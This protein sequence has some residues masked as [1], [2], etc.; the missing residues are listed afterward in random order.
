MGDLRYALHRCSWAFAAALT[1]CAVTCAASAA[2]A[3]ATLTVSTEGASLTGRIWFPKSGRPPFPAVVLVHGSGRMTRDDMQYAR[4][5]ML[6]MGLAVLGYDKRG[7]GESTGEYD[8]V[9]V[10][11][12]PTRMPLLGRDALAMLR[13]LRRHDGVDAS[14]VGF[15]GVSQAGWIIPAALGGAR[16]GE[17]GFA[18]IQSGP[19]GS[20]GD[21][22]A[23][24]QATGDGIRSHDD[25]TPEQIDARVDAYEG[26]AGF[27]NLPILRR[28]RT[29]LLWLVGEAD[30]SIPVRHTLRNLKALADGGVPI[31]LRT[32]PGANHSL[33][34]P[35]GPVPFWDDVRAWLKQQRVLD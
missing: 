20:V 8:D 2:T 31:A 35:S 13:A 25:L 7:V 10:F 11:T 15:F 6:S 16:S 26:P 1:A 21:E 3:D 4:A 27:D 19:A 28:V 5:H 33:S 34:A 22:Y 18:I 9:G 23:Y 29:P 24:S 30:E 12:S 14:R 32:Y 17:V